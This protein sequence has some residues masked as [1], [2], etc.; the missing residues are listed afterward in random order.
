MST[1]QF[2]DWALARLLRLCSPMLPVGAFSYSQGLEAAAELGWLSDEA[3]AKR[4][5]GAALTHSVACF[6]APIWC[7]LYQAWQAR[8]AQG[9]AAWNEVFLAGRESAEFRA[10]TLQMGYSLRALLLEGADF[11]E[12]QIA[13]L[14]AVEN[15][16]FPAAFSFACAGWRI[17]E[18]EGLLG[19]LWAWLENQ[20][21]AAM[22]TIPLGQTAGQRLLAA[23]GGVLPSV[24]ETALNMAD[25][26]MSN[27]APSLAIASCRHETQYSRLFRS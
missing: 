24:T 20:A 10:E 6:E 2:D 7:R 17:P 26:E 3:S 22:K 12:G 23:L 18:R 16:A 5:I 15:P 1:Q 4:W 25:D 8:D 27:C 19:Y 21:A 9:V 11:D 13:A 14:R